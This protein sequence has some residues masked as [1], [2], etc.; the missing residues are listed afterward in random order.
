[1]PAND[2]GWTPRLVPSGSDAEG[3]VSPGP[4]IG[5]FLSTGYTNGLSMQLDLA[6]FAPGNGLGTQPLGPALVLW[7]PDTSP[8]GNYASTLTLTLVSP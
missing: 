6:V 5:P 4:S 2:L 8:T 1:V 7:I 3:V